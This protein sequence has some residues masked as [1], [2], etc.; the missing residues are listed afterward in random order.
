ME[1]YKYVIVFNR[2]IEE[3]IRE[4]LQAHHAV[5]TQQATVMTCLVR[6]N[7]MNMDSIHFMQDHGI[8]ME[9]Y[10]YVCGI[11]TNL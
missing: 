10:M 3:I 6:W 1:E 2:Y 4:Q 8:Q 7:I 11:V 9:K 5:Q